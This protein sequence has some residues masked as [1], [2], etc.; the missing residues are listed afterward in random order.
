MPTLSKLPG[1]L[2][3]RTIRLY[4]R[5]RNLHAAP[6]ELWAAGLADE[7][8]FWREYLRTGGSQ[9]PDAYQSRIDPESE[10]QEHIVQRLSGLGQR[11]SMLDAGAGPL[12]AVGK[13]WAGHEF[14]LTAVDA[15]ADQYDALLAEF[16]VTPPVRTRR[17]D[18]ERLSEEFAADSF[19][20]AYA[21][22]TLDH[23]YEPMQAI[24]EMLTVVRP[25]GIVLLE[26]F[27]NEAENEA[28]R[29]LHQWNFDV[30]GTDC[31]LWR[32]GARWRLAEELAQTATV[33]AVREDAIV[34]VVITKS[35][36]P[37]PDAAAEGT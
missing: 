35:D 23:S 28:Y 4:R 30:D 2:K 34:I 32:P 18:T 21:V 14:T 11:V 33:H 24:R 20:V 27:A 5:R 26:H 8:D 17:C 6:Q 19:D 22:N 37:A 15:L 36:S 31:V 1:N 9:W 10:L 29:G 12:T 25:G 3:Y 7:T 13:K 16:G